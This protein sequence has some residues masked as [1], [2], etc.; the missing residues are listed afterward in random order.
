MYEYHPSGL[1]P[2]IE[3]PVHTGEISA[4]ARGKSINIQDHGSPLLDFP[5]QLARAQHAPSSRFS[6][7]P[8][9]LS[10]LL[11][12][13]FFS[14]G[15]FYT[16]SPNFSP[17]CLLCRLLCSLLPCYCFPIPPFSSSSALVSFTFLPASLNSFSVLVIWGLQVHKIIKLF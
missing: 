6:H 15:L 17:S 12:S 3:F 13:S 2:V 1:P 14:N 11:L 7:P 9:L 4:G 5:A 16:V 10:H 8:C